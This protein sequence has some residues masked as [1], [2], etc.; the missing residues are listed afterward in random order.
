IVAESTHRTITVVKPVINKSDLVVE[1]AYEGE[2]SGTVTVNVSGIVSLEYY[3]ENNSASKTRV[4]GNVITGLSKGKYYVYTPAYTDGDTFYIASSKLPATI[5]ETEKPKYLIKTVAGDNLSWTKSEVEIFVKSSTSV[6]VRPA[7][8]Y[9]ISRVYALPEGNADVSW[10][11]STNEVFVSNIT[12][13]ITLYAEATAKNAPAKIEITGVSFNEN[14]IYSEE[15]PYIQTEITVKLTDR[16]GNPVPETDVYFKTDKTEVSYIRKTTDKDGVAVLKNPYGIA[17]E[18]GDLSAS[19]SPIVSADGNFET[20]TVETEVNLVLQQKKNLELYEDQ[21]TGSRPEYKEGSVKNV[22]DGYEIWTGEVHDAVIVLYTGTWEGPVDGEFTG[23]SSGWQLLRF[24]EKVD[25]ETNTFWF[26]SDH[27]PF[28]VPRIEHAV[29]ADD[30]E[31]TDTVDDNNTP[32]DDQGGSTVPSE[33]PA[34][35]AQNNE[36]AASQGGTDNTPAVTPAAPRNNAPADNEEADEASDEE[37]VE[38]AEPEET[39]EEE[40]PDE[41]PAAEDSVDQATEEVIN[42]EDVALAAGPAEAEK[43]PNFVLW[44]VLALAVLIVITAGT[45]GYYRFRKNSV[46]E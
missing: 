36:P 34:A 26:A 39:A 41:E 20:L 15:N 3:K 25:A 11:E 35:P 18:R 45:Y 31:P 4:E 1:S 38:E 9:Y 29:I 43:A 37:P 19:Y 5:G 10:Y 7:E 8:E 13:N 44:G 30:E 46:K 12:G 42:E 27:E 24:G 6:Y 40:T 28:Y 32:A 17:V 14:G 33:E 21:I 2:D 23:L 22:P 16:D